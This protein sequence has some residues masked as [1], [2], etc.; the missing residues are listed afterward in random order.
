MIQPK[1]SIFPEGDGINAVEAA[2][3]CLVALICRVSQCQPY[4]SNNSIK[5]GFGNF[6]FHCEF[7]NVVVG[8]V[9][10]TQS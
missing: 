5:I 9:S 6:A 7:N 2:D 1:L 8:V 4:L 10:V 3:F